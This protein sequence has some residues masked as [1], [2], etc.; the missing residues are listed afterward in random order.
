MDVAS[1]AC[2]HRVWSVMRSVGLGICLWLGLWES[3]RSQESAPAPAP[4]PDAVER[5]LERAGTNRVELVRA[6]EQIPESRR[7]G[8]EFLIE[9]MPVRDLTT[10]TAAFLLEHVELAYVGWE[11]A[12]WRTSIPS[13][14]FLNDVLPYVSLDERRE[15][16]RPRL[17]EIA[18]PMVRDAQ[19]PTEAVRILN[20]RLFAEHNVK[21]STRR[22]APNQPSLET[23]ESG[24]ATC[25]GLSILLVDACRAVGIPA[26]VVG[27]PLWTNQ[28]GNH[29]WVEIWDGDWHFVGAAEPDP[30]GLNRGWFVGQASQAIEDHPAHAI[31]A[32]SFRRTGLAFPL[33]WARSTTDVPAVNVTRRYAGAAPPLDPALLMLRINVLD[34]PRGQR[35]AARVT[36][37]DTENRTNRFSGISKTEPADMNDHLGFAVPRQRTYTVDVQQGE[38]RQ[39]QYYTSSMTT[40]EDRLVI[41]LAGAPKVIAPAPEVEAAPSADLPELRP[42]Q[43]DALKTALT[44]YFSATPEQRAI[45][46]FPRRLDRWV[47]RHEPAVR[48]LAWET[49]RDSPIHTD[50]RT[51]FDAH[52]VRSGEHVSPYTLKKVGTRPEG[53]WPLFI[54]M[55]GG[56][57]VAQEVNDR[58]WQHMQIY[59]R[60]H[61]QLGGY[62]YLALRAPNNEWNGF[63]TGYVYPLIENLIRQS[64]LFG[65]VNP[66]KVFLMGYSHGGY[67]AYAIGPKMPDRFAAIHSSAAAPADG[68]EPDTLRNVFFT[69][70]LGERDTAYQRQDLN[71]EFANAVA[72]LRGERTDIY[73]FTFTLIANH[74]HSGLPDRDKIPE[75]YP[76]VRNPVPREL[77]WRQTDDVIRGHYWLVTEEPGRGRTLRATR[78][79]NRIQVT[80]EGQVGRSRLLLDSRLVTFAEP[81]T[82]ELNGESRTERLRP[83][84]RILAESLMLRGDPE[85]AFTAEWPIPATPPATAS[86]PTVP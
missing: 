30:E 37:T 32:T 84:L 31:F 44:D 65:D 7:P 56:G 24:T 12:P 68:A 39:R 52:R 69:V 85:L 76:A 15:A 78:Q 21:Y 83:S 13:E 18:A 2:G 5:A 27:T 59:Y 9:N 77:S 11:K 33:V 61:P 81:I 28:S 14:I 57:G 46:E 73:P 72:R 50:M 23:L 51:E 71:R 40:P 8:M 55:H 35:V 42:G 36:V 63:Y 54:A 66:N 74:P 20:Q 1:C 82:V 25:T 86:T 67:G 53:G 41:H 58:Q 17:M 62:Q 4:W 10:L 49:Y 80:T 43:Q 70:M 47:A 3:A 60:D 38:V 48:R 29:T 26:R 64:L 6:L 19:T 22:R 16:W 79:N 45:W 34:V 75:M